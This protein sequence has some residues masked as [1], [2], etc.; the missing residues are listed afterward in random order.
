[1]TPYELKRKY[2]EAHP[3][4]YFFTR[5]NMKFAGDTMRN[6]GVRDAG[7]HWELYRKKPVLFGGLSAFYFD[8]QTFRIATTLPEGGK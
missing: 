5:N 2:K 8:K 6:F 3:D 4:N 7:T 1:M